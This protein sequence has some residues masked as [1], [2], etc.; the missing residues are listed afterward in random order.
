MDLQFAPAHKV[1]MKDYNSSQNLF[2]LLVYIFLISTKFFYDIL[3]SMKLDLI[4]STKFK[5]IANDQGH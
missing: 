2:S 5:F 3:N 4:V 1:V